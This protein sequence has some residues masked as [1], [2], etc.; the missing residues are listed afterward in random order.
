MWAGGERIRYVKK[1]LPRRFTLAVDTDDFSYSFAVGLPKPSALPPGRSLFSADPEVKEENLWL[2]GA[3]K[4]VLMLDRRGP[5]AWLRNADGAMDEYAFE[6]VKYESVLPQIIEAH[7]Y[8]EIH[9]A[10]QALLGWRFY[11]HFRT[12]LDS[13]LRSPQIGV[14]TTV[15]HHDGSD[16]AAALET[17]LEI[18]DAEALNTAVANAFRGARLRIEATDGLFR[19]ELEIPGLLRALSARELS[20]GQLRYLCL[21]AALLSPRPPSLIALNEPETSL[22]PDLYEPLAEMIARAARQTQVWITTHAEG[23]VRCLTKTAQ[24]EPA[25]VVLIEGETWLASNENTPRRPHRKIVA[26]GEQG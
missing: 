24:T 15:L 14:Q 4:P 6:L 2:L 12:D 5:T 13:P 8:P 21:A 1:K 11:H 7:R 16:L 22:H 23:L 20:D 9:L 3:G 18:G 25:E 17:I 10:R 19:L 26:P